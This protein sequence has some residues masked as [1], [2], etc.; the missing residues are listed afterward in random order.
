MQTLIGLE[1]H[2]QLA[3]KTKMF[4]GCPNVAEPKGPNLSVCPVCLGLPGSLPVANRQAIEMAMRLGLALGGQVTKFSKFDR[5][6]YFYPDL[7]KGYQIS[8]Y[9]KPIINGGELTIETSETPATGKRTT[10][11]V[12][13]IRIHLEEDAAKSTHPK[14]TDYS[15]IDFNRAGT[16]LLESVTE[17]DMSTPQE[18]RAFVAAFRTILRYLKISNADMEKG[19]LRVDA[20][21]NVV[22]GKRKTPIT[23]IKNMNSLRAIE[24]AL[25]FEVKRHTS[26]LTEGREGEL[27]KETRGWD[28]ARGETVSQRS[29]EVASDYRYFPEPD[30]PPLEPERQLVARLERTI[31]ELPLAKAARFSREYGITAKAAR[32]LAAEADLANY[33]EQVA[34]ELEAW[35]ESTGSKL[36]KK[37]RLKLWQNAANWI[38]VELTKHLN[39]AQM[40]IGEVHITPENFAEFLLIVQ[41]GKINSSAAQIVLA[42][43]FL[44]GSDPST[45]IQD[46]N[47]EQVSDTGALAAAVTKVIAANPKPV[48]DVQAGKTKALQFLV[49][50]VMKETH[51]KANPGMV[52]ELLKK[53]LPPLS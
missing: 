12:R 7:P 29:K 5:K 8:Q 40:Q 23:E 34:G 48:A 26:A 49:G 46:Q 31:P 18:A 33:F 15:L 22:D 37:D 44:N 43:M 21:I 19:Q 45:V 38:L 24:R 50:M 52:Q 42:D 51:A 16:P 11:K 35:A 3:S 6:N 4:C 10:K 2:T 47:L 41:Q 9:D 14:S 32:Q 36:T 13:L 27:I 53:K 28:E 30:I 1:I 17:P 25:A 20:N 39:K